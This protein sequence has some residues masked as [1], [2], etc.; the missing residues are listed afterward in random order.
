MFS[1]TYDVI[2]IDSDLEGTTAIGTRRAIDLSPN[3]FRYYSNF[4]IELGICKVAITLQIGT[5]LPVSILVVA[6]IPVDKRN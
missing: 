3:S 2:C 1:E 4:A 6:R 5:K